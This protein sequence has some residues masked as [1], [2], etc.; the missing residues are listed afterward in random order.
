[1][2][3]KHEGPEALGRLRYGRLRF[4]FS[5]QGA[6]DL[7]PHPGSAWRGAFGWSLRELAC[8]TGAADCRGCALAE[9]CIYQRLFE[10]AHHGPTKPGMSGD[11]SPHPFVLEIPDSA[12]HAPYVALDVHLIGDGLAYAGEVA[13][14]LAR[15]GRRGIGGTRNRLALARVQQRLPQGWQDILGPGGQVA[16]RPWEDIAPPALPADTV[17]VRLTSPLRLVR[18]NR[19]LTAEALTPRVFIHALYARVRKLWRAQDLPEDGYWPEIPAQTR[20]PERR[21]HWVELSRYSNRQGRRHPI[22]G[23]MGEFTL[24]VKELHELWPLLW[25]GQYLHLGKLTSL[26]HGAYRIA[27]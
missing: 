6:L 19:P 10:G 4:L 7:P 27:V 8:V 11:R 3:Q 13:L 18:Q 20:F 14:A 12:P 24:D 23:L 2:D 17:R 5:A 22:G 25:H 15:A 9:R 21:L 1:M 26:G 16:P